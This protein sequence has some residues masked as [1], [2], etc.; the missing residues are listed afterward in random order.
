MQEQRSKLPTECEPAEHLVVFEIAVFENGDHEGDVGQLELR[1]MEHEGLLVER[2]RLT[3][4]Y[5][6]LTPRDLLPIWSDHAQFDVRVY[7]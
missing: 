2:I 4:S 3:A 6:R 1:N 5:R 7:M